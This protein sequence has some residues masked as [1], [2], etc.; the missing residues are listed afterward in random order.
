VVADGL[1]AVEGAVQVDLL[2]STLVL[3]EI[4]CEGSVSYL[5][6][7]VP[8]LDGAVED[9]GVGGGTSVGNE[10]IDL[11]EVGNDILDELLDALV[12]VHCKGN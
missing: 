9:A 7:V 2:E 11:A 6:D 1:G 4:R 3:L 8:G 5:H 12:L 10:G